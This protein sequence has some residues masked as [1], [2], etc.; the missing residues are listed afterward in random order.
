MEA[1]KEMNKNELIFCNKNRHKS[2]IISDA[3]FVKIIP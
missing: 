2:L 1:Q 3:R